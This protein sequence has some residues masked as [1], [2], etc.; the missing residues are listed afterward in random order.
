MPWWSWVLIWFGL[1]LA[2]VGVMAIFGWH[3][4]KKLMVTF[5][6]LE[7]LAIRDGY[8][9][10][11]RVTAF[12]KLYYDSESSG[13][14]YPGAPSGGVWNILIPGA[15][16]TSLPPSWRARATATKVTTLAATKVLPI[17]LVRVDVGH[18]LTGL[19]ARNHLTTVSLGVLGFPLVRMRS[20]LE[21]ATF[22]GDLGSVVVEYLRASK[23][24]FRDTAME[25]DATLLD[26][27]FEKFAPG[28]DLAADADAYLVPV[29]PSRS[30][31]LNLSSYYRTT[32]GGWRRRWQGFAQAIG[33]GVFT[34]APAVKGSY[35][36][37]KVVG[38]FSGSTKK[39][40]GDVRE[41][42]FNAALAYAAVSGKRVDVVNVIREPG[43][44]VIIPTFWEMYWNASGWALDEFLFRLKRAVNAEISP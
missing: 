34:P 17:D 29:D 42:V 18:V 6:D 44:G 1:F 40:H 38:T 13:A 12:R 23:R 21:A 37:T 31:A 19:D 22:V 28:S 33:L 24:S 10:V 35:W 14:A 39:W 15:V 2:L 5:H 7:K 8:S 20:N 30:F 41:Q 3:L 43:P 27:T 11:Q 9:L 26:T 25:L 32:V 4:F 16:S 36:Q